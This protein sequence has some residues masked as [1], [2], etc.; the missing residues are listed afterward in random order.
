M[1]VQ[2]NREHPPRQTRPNEARWILHTWHR[3]PLKFS[4]RS[5][6]NKPQYTGLVFYLTRCRPAMLS[7]TTRAAEKL[8]SLDPNM[9]RGFK[10]FSIPAQE[11][12]KSKSAHP[13]ERG[14][15]GFITR[16][17]K[18]KKRRYNIFFLLREKKKK[19]YKNY[20]LGRSDRVEPQIWKLSDQNL[21]VLLSDL[22][23]LVVAV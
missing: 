22:Q 5:W 12:S 13:V 10:S 14:H 2:F 20:P 16:Y 15:T 3:S 17:H 7:W 8:L 4:T 23:P 18:L 21:Y 9:I 19:R 1:S 6:I 11:R